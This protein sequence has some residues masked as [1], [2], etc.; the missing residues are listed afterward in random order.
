MAVIEK[1]NNE[2]S[3]QNT[4]PTLLYI[5]DEAH[6][7]VS[8]KAVFRRDFI[9]ETALSVDE[10]KPL[11][12]DPNLC[13]IVSDQRMPGTTGVEFF[14]KIKESHPNPIR[15][16]LTGYSDIEAVIDAINKGEV[17]RYLT[18][19]WDENFMKSVLS[20]ALEIYNLRKENKQLVADLKRANEQ[21][22]FYLRQKLLS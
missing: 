8:F 22:E 18:K 14:S 15:I 19:P 2:E 6:N 13:I 9:V 10:A 5:D 12:T 7:L 4:K 1:K 3:E 16:L 17:Y 21:L 20:Q 11:L